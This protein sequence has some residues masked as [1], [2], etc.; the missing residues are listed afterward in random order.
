MTSVKILLIDDEK[1]FTEML[2]DYFGRN[3]K[4]HGLD[5][6]VVSARSAAAAERLFAEERFNPDVILLDN[7]FSESG[8]AEDEGFSQI[9]KQ[10]HVWRGQYTVPSDKVKIICISGRLSPNQSPTASRATISWGAHAYFDKKDLT[11][12]DRLISEIARLVQE[13]SK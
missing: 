8:G 1:L 3:G 12:D 4:K 6:V 7:D 2:E 11:A 9:I 13:A 5:C 10:F